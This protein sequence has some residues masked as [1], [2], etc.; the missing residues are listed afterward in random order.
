ML[1][2][3]AN[4]TVE[5]LVE[6]VLLVPQ[7]RNALT[8]PCPELRIAP[9]VA[10][11][12]INI[13]DATVPGTIPS[14]APRT[15]SAAILVQAPERLTTGNEALDQLLQGGVQRGH[16]LELSGPPGSPK[17]LATMSIIEQFALAGERVIVV[18]VC[19]LLFRQTKESH[20]IAPQIART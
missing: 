20:L 5:T 16:I 6:G 15:Q 12:I 8:I 11:R 2:D 10:K 19:P 18:G 14:T 13:R 1:K 7:V 17:E 4:T 3:L 9:E